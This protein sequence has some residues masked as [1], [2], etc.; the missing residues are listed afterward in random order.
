MGGE[1]FTLSVGE[2]R[3]FE[4]LMSV[5]NA[6]A[7]LPDLVSWTSVNTYRGGTASLKVYLRRPTPGTELAEELEKLLGRHLAL[8]AID[9]QNLELR[10]A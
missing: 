2:L 8:A 9:E 10:V 3:S 7:H 1:P 4:E 6:L 5:N